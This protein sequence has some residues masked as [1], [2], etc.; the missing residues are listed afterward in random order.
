MA[1]GNSTARVVAGFEGAHG[2]VPALRYVA[3]SRWLHWTMAALMAVVIVAGIWIKYFE[4]ADEPFKMRLYNLHES[5]GVVVFVLALVRLVN[6]WRHP[7]P[8]LPAGTPAVI[9][10]A[11]GVTHMALYAL[12]LLMPV[13]GFLAT[14]AWGFP[15]TVFGVRPMPVPL[16]KN[17]ELAK[18]LSLLHLS[19]AIAVVLLIGGHLMGVVYHTFVRRDG[20]LRR[21]M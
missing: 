20:L 18:L 9:H 5:V 16:G 17:E 10:L 21:M 4:P 8:P 12:L 3:S 7:P 13:I 6:R 19:G 15:L 2:T 14:N 1:Q 11:A